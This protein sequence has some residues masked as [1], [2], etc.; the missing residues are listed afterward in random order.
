MRSN[1]KDQLI[2]TKKKKIISN[3]KMYDYLNPRDTHDDRPVQYH[4]E[5]A[6]PNET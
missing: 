2:V 6:W 3:V 5:K 4:V 1:N